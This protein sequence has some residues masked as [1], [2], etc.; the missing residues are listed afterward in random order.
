MSQDKYD[1][2][3]RAVLGEI[4]ARPMIEG[5]PITVPYE[6]TERWIAI[7]LRESAA[8]AYE[9]A[10]QRILDFGR[11]SCERTSCDLCDFVTG[12]RSLAG[13]LRA[14]SAGGKP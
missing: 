12:L 6:S 4:R 3:A 7:A 10:A 1:D 14:A 8:E 5:T 2:K 11:C 13:N 9:D